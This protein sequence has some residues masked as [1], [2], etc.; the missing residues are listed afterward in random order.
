MS[1]FCF[2]GFFLLGFVLLGELVDGWFYGD[3]NMTICSE[4][5]GGNWEGGDFKKKREEDDV[6][7]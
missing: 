6:K 4:E 2:G 1:I 7:K 5:E 3:V